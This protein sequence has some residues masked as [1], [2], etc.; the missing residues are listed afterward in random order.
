MIVELADDHRRAWLRRTG[1]ERAPGVD[2][3]VS[4]PVEDVRKTE[5]IEALERAYVVQGTLDA[6]D[7][8]SRRQ[9]SR[10]HRRMRREVFLEKDM[11][12]KRILPSERRLQP[13][14]EGPL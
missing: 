13:A 1:Q 3:R 2:G 9:P 4:R 12:E 7:R 6:L 14:L 10:V 5:E 11:L 8:R